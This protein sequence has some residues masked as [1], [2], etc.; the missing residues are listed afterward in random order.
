M[1]SE[2]LTKLDPAYTKQLNVVGLLEH[3]VNALLG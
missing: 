1:D 3:F 2:P